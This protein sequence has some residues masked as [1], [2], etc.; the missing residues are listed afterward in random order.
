MKPRA[1]E[2][3][4]HTH[5]MSFNMRDVLPGDA[6]IFSRTGPSLVVAT[7][8]GSCDRVHAYRRIVMVSPDGSIEDSL[9]RIDFFVL[10][11]GGDEVS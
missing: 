4:V 11:P 9:W 7:L 5:Y 2:L 1:P 6:V 10:A 3:K 8:P